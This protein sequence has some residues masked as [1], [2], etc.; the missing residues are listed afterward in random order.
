MEAINK[1]M[2][3]PYGWGNHLHVLILF[4]TCRP[5][6]SDACYSL[7][8]TDSEDNVSIFGALGP[9]SSPLPP[10]HQIYHCMDNVLYFSILFLGAWMWFEWSMLNIVFVFLFKVSGV[11]RGLDKCAELLTNILEIK[12][13]GKGMGLWL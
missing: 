9:L 11:N 12:Y 10:P 5:G 8:F 7:Y 2:W 1:L 3:D 4:H 6:S 13:E